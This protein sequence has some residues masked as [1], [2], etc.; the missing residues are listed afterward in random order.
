MSI[1]HFLIIFNIVGINH[2]IYNIIKI[3][4]FVLILLALNLL[5]DYNV[6]STAVICCNWFQ[7]LNLNNSVTAVVLIGLDY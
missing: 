5:L 4:F 7:F 1:F 2:I 3:H 6:A